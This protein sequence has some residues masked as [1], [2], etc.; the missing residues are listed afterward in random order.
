MDITQ[1]FVDEWSAKW[2][3]FICFIHDGQRWYEITRNSNLTMKTIRDN[4][5]KPWDWYGA[6][7]NP[8]LTAKFRNL[9]IPAKPQGNWYYEYNIVNSI[10]DM[11]TN[12][13]TISSNS[14]MLSSNPNLTL[15]IIQCGIEN[16]WNWDWYYLSK[17]SCITPDII[18][19]NPNLPWDWEQISYNPNVTMDFIRRNRDKKFVWRRL[20]ENGNIT[21]D[22]IFANL[23]LPWT[24]RDITE[25]PNLTIRL[26]HKH[27]KRDNLVCMVR[28]YWFYMHELSTDK[29][30]Y[31]SYNV[32][33]MNILKMHKFYNENP[34]EVALPI[35]Y[36]VFDNYLVK[37]ILQY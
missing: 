18:D 15:E 5:T 12:G 7:F 23:D 19:N 20:A 31:I 35:E 16:G 37:Q 4:P 11:R 8:I 3:E 26:I 9:H 34:Y 6:L 25:N 22:M 13:S 2:F 14:H 24:I 27:Y 36:V 32:R 29:Q 30:M 17:N 21:M 28:H 33:N 10:F 1:I